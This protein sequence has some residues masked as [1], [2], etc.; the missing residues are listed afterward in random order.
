MNHLIKTLLALFL[1]V[2]GAACVNQDFDEPPVEGIDPGITP[3]ATIAELKA[4]YRPGSLTA[5]E[6]DITIGG[7][8]V[9]DDRS[10]NF[11]RSF[12]LQDASGGI[13]ILINQTNFYNFFPIGRELFIKCKGLVIGESNGVLQLGGYVFVQNGAQQLGDIIALDDHIIRG[14]RVGD[15]EP[16]IRTINS[17][18]TADVSTLVRLENVEFDAVELGFP[19]GDAVGRRTL[20]RTLKD[21]SGATIAVRTSGF[22]TFAS[23][24]VAGGNGTITGIYSVFG[25]TKQLFIRE[26]SDVVMNGD[27]CSGGGGGTPGAEELMTIQE[28]RNLFSAGTVVGPSNRKIKGVV[29]SDRENNNWDGRNLVIQDETAGIAVRFNS[30]HNFSLGQEIEVAISGQELSEF[31]SLLQVN[32][33]PNNV[34]RSLG[35]GVLPEPQ[36]VTVGQIIGNIKT[37]ESKLVRIKGATIAAGTYSGS[38][39]VNDGTGAVPMFTRSQASFA[40]QNV[41]SGTVDVTAVVSIFN[42]PQILIRNTSDIVAG[43]GG[44]G[45]NPGG[46]G[47]ESLTIK[48]IRDLFR[49]GTTVGPAGR[50]IKGVVISDRENN[51]W[52]GRNLV[53]QDA[54][55]GIVVRFAAAHNFSLGQEIEVSVGGQELSQFNGLLQVNNVPGNMATLIGAG[56]L[57]TPREATINQLIANLNDWE[58]TLV[59]I[60]NATIAAGTFSGS[61]NVNDGTGTLPMFTRTQATFAGQNV[62][63]GTV[64]ITA[65]LS[66]F[67]TAQIIIRSP[68]DIK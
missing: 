3:D 38:R 60:K 47:S 40:G 36:E 7:V 6:Q 27:R 14:K 52:D 44:G 37:W 41:P 35:M 11:F 62:P 8:V 55:A 18:S 1:L 46:G 45:G 19:Y 23:A 58:S 2:G 31:R 5:V 61:R 67:N 24:Q 13:Q 25:T 66:R 21:C 64:E 53:I 50:K 30:N 68:A 57:P 12:V 22:A 17:L 42:D 20:N 56:T 51:N 63:G 9:A 4:L 15:P 49:A 33:V 16:R 48:E 43:T 65:V 32:N 34:A 54:T 28:V 39:N 26:L 10:G 29:I 59:T